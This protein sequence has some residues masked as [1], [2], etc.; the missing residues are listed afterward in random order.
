[1]IEARVIMLSNMVKKYLWKV[2]WKSGREKYRNKGVLSTLHCNSY[3]VGTADCDDIRL[4]YSNHQ[5][6]I[7]K[8]GS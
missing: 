2:Y 7:D 4:T 6:N 1:M 3:N 8:R 5:E